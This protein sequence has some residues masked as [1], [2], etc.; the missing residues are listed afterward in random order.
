MCISYGTYCFTCTYTV[1][2]WRTL[3][4]ASSCERKLPS[5]AVFD[6]IFVYFWYTMA[7]IQI[8]TK[9]YTKDGTKSEL[10]QSISHN[11]AHCLIVLLFVW[12]LSDVTR[13][14]LGKNHLRQAQIPSVAKSTA[15][16]IV[17][18]Y[19]LPVS[20]G[21]QYAEMH[22]ILRVLIYKSVIF[23][24]EGCQH[25]ETWDASINTLNEVLVLSRGAQ[26][27]V[28]SDILVRSQTLQARRCSH[29]GCVIRFHC[30]IF[31]NTI[32]SKFLPWHPP[33]RFTTLT[34]IMEIPG[35]N[36]YN[37][38]QTV[39]IQTTFHRLRL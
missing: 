13:Q 15:V 10:K 14:E 37:T 27:H 2:T 17:S 16:L 4:H 28:D 12:L 39:V 5:P 34:E 35:Y 31:E 21:S 36:A 26:Q 32:H 19:I 9:R 8:E 20:I 18:R 25:G 29:I 33:S 30:W 38:K 11:Y 7:L 23:L 24:D 6:E 1:G 3:Q 22:P